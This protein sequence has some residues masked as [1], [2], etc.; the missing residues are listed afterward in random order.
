MDSRAPKAAASS[1]SPGALSTGVRFTP[2]D[3]QPM[4]MPASTANFQDPM[5]P[6]LPQPLAALKPKSVR[7]SRIE[8]Y[9]FLRIAP[10]VQ[11]NARAAGL[12]EL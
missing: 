7:R 11:R 8:A 9:V 12:S 2:A 4:Q 10:A 3:A 1:S 5:G 6:S